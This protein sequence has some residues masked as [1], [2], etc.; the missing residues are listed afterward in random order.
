MQ[1][2]Y[3]VYILTDA[4]HKTLYTGVTNDLKRRVF[5]HK[6]GLHDGF[7]KKYHVNMLTYYEIFDA[8]EYAILREKQ[9]KGGSRQQKI[10]LINSINKEWRDLYEDVVTF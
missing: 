6:N 3:F 8:I 10:D 5:E 4:K 1:R 7:T 2:Q 9:L